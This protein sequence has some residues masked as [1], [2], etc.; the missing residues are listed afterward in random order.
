MK[1]KQPSFLKQHPPCVRRER[2]NMHL[3]MCVQKF[4]A[5]RRTLFHPLPQSS[6]II[7]PSHWE[8]TR[9]STWP[10][11]DLNVICG[12]SSEELWRWSMFCLWACP[13][14]HASTHLQHRGGE[15]QEEVRLKRRLD[16]SWWEDRVSG[17]MNGSRSE[18]KKQKVNEYNV[19]V[20]EAINIS[21]DVQLQPWRPDNMNPRSG[22]KHTLVFVHSCYKVS[23]KRNVVLEQTYE[24]GRNF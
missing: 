14:G 20:K 17:S 1:R 8:Q 5:S 3:T 13:A 19:C 6:L 21:S 12:A 10:C 16:P 18:K 22:Q 15:T 23:E 2:I 7:I 9:S 4:R 24:L 11:E